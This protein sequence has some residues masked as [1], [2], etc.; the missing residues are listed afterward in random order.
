[1]KHKKHCISTQ[2]VTHAPELIII[3]VVQGQHESYELIMRLSGAE[4]L[5][6]SCGKDC[7]P[8]GISVRAYLGRPCK[9][10][11]CSVDLCI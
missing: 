6:C 10:G 9:S 5:C 3:H 4:I 11:S 7:L 1:M 8:M 2:S